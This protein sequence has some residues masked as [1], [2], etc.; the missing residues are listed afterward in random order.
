M[1]S[2]ASWPEGDAVTEE[3]WRTCENPDAMLD[4][5]AGSPRATNR[6][7]RLFACGCVRRAWD[8]LQGDNEEPVRRA[9]EFAERL[10]EGGA[11]AAE[12]A[13]MGRD[14]FS[15]M[16]F[17]AEQVGDFFGDAAKPEWS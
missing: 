7:L 15:H 17:W 14:L 6:R 2:T 10:A 9:V 5:I 4:A 3:Q 16:D 8:L 12:R 13:A 1:V 11:D